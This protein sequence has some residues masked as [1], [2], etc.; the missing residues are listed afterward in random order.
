MCRGAR[1]L[2]PGADELAIVAAIDAVADGGAEFLGIDPSGYLVLKIKNGSV[3]L[4]LFR[5]QKLFQNG[6][7]LKTPKRHVAR[8]ARISMHCS[9]NKDS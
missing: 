6:T 9:R 5:K 1:E 4:R 8:G 3:S 2:V 7:L